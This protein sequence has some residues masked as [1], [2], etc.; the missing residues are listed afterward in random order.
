MTPYCHIH[1]KAIGPNRNYYRIYFDFIP[2]FCFW[3][4][5]AR[6]IFFNKLLILYTTENELTKQNRH[7]QG[8]LYF[9]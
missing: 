1:K 6:V 8:I 7:F 9:V 4:L 3:K 2:R 5:P